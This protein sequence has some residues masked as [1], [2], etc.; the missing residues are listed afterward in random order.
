ML[1]D[2]SEGTPKLSVKEG[3]QGM[4]VPGLRIV[5][6]TSSDEVLALMKAG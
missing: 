1:A 3:P 4:Y 2:R 6:V 5:P